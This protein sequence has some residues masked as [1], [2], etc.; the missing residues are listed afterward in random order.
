M[1]HV[2]A[3]AASLGVLEGQVEPFRQVEVELD[4]G[5]LPGAAD[6]VGN[7]VCLSW[8][9][10]R[11]RLPSSTSKA[12]PRCSKALRR[13]LV[14]WSHISGSPTYFS[15]AGCQGDGV[16]G[17]TEGLEQL[18]GEVEDSAN[19]G[20]NLVGLAEDVG[21]V[22]GKA[23]DSHQAVKHAAALVAVDGTQLGEAYGQ[24]PVAAGGT[25]GKS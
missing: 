4:G 2:G 15:G 9:R 5:A 22:L 17:E 7:G 19:F 20:F 12:M 14:A 13:E 23:A 21:V 6:G 25:S 3:A 8:A 10:R 11:P 16:V 1:H 18:Q 24:F